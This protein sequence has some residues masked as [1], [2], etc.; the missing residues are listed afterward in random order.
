MTIA[1]RLGST[2]TSRRLERQTSLRRQTAVAI[3]IS[4]C[5]LLFLV[6]TVMTSLTFSIIWLVIGMAFLAGV[7]GIHPA[8][9]RKRHMLERQLTL[10]LDRAYGYQ[11]IVGRT[12][13]PEDEQYA[14]WSIRTT[15]YDKQFAVGL[16]LWEY[17]AGTGWDWCRQMVTADGLVLGPRE[18]WNGITKYPGFTCDQ[19]Q[20]FIEKMQDSTCWIAYHAGNKDVDTMAS[21]PLPTTLIKQKIAYWNGPGDTDEK[22]PHFWEI[23]FDLSEGQER[24]QLEHF[25]VWLGEQVRLLNQQSRREHLDE[26]AAIEDAHIEAAYFHEL[27]ES[28]A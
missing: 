27:A 16:H 22:R 11:A 2:P 13:A 21:S 25:I 17:S 26:L 4:S 18:A 19:Q 12:D 24:A 23:R 15:H 6:A 8:H 3:A 20:E 1:K 9:T 14:H 5:S 28:A 7:A 10:E